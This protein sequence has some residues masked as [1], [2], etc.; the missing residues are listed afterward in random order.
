MLRWFFYLSLTF[1]LFSC[2]NDLEKIQKITLKNTDPNE[3]IKNLQLLFSDSGYAKVRV[4]ASLAE[5]YYS[6]KNVTLLKDSLCVYFYDSEG[7]V[8]TTLT[9]KYGEYYP[10]ENRIVVQNKVILTKP[11]NNQKME[12][13]ELIWKQ[14]DSSIYSNRTVTITTPNGKFYGD[15]IKSKQDFSYYEFIRPHGKITQ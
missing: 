12:T 13:E 9:G 15:G 8:E 2:V 10:N 3:R 6:P 4:Y 7:K 14:V 1:T 11:T 5:T